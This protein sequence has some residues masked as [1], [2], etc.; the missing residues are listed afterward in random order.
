M[1]INRTMPRRYWG[2]ALTTATMLRDDGLEVLVMASLAEQAIHEGRARDGHDLARA[3]R[4]RAEAL[5][6]PVLVSILAAREARALVLKGERAAASRS[7]M[8]AMRSLHSPGRAAPEWTDFH[9]QAEL[10]Y[11]QGM[12]Y[13]GAGHYHAA[14]PFLRAALAHQGQ[15]YCRNRA[16]YQVTLARTLVQAGEVEEGASEAV[17]SLGHLS[18][19]ESGRVNERLVG[20]RTLLVG[21]GASAVK[22]SIQALDAYANGEA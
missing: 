6:S 7:M 19:V 10:E 13:V 17:E 3:A 14:V 21:S 8:Q 18:E 9:G 11:A 15:S 5:G 12:L 1:L 16:L 22:G 20:V 2:E 4:E